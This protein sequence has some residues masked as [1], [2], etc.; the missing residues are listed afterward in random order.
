MKFF[1]VY[2]STLKLY[3]V[4]GAEPEEEDEED[5]HEDGAADREL[6]RTPDVRHSSG[7]RLQNCDETV[8]PQY[9][10]TWRTGRGT[11]S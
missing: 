4:S 6:P 1:L 11:C 2:T 5:L 3:G 7:T 9:L 8:R 10:P